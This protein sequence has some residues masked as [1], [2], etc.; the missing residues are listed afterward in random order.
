MDAYS[1]LI[2]PYVQNINFIRTKIINTLMKLQMMKGGQR[3]AVS[4]E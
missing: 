4:V 2:H 1:F 3:S